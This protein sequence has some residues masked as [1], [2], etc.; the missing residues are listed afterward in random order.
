MEQKETGTPSVRYSENRC[1]N[2]EDIWADQ[3]EFNRLILPCTPED[4][5]PEQRQFWH[6]KYTLLLN[7]EL[8]EVLDETEFK[9]HRKITGK[10]VR[11]NMTEELVDVFKYWMCLCQVH[12]VNAEEIMDEYHR[13]SNVVKQRYFQEKVLNYDG[14]IVGV[15]IDGVL[16]DYPRS[17]VEFV[18]QQLG[19]DYN[20]KTVKGYD[21]VSELKL[22]EHGKRLKHLYRDSGQKRFIPVVEGARQFL[23]ELKYMGYIVVLLTSRPINEYK[24]IFADTQYWLAA[25]KLHYD[26]I[27]FDE[28]KGERLV[29]E[30]GR[31][32]VEFFVDDVAGFAN[33]ISEAGFRCYLINKSYNTDVKVNDG[34]TRV[35]DLREVILRARVEKHRRAQK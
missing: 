33:G 22:G 12:G 34:V 1:N 35:D 23:E 10:M 27:L 8:M 20:C 3:Y 25:N 19:T 30:F 5:T 24:R 28:A 9:P 29:K 2:L 32:K 6:E 31:D 15:D 4:M 17:F 16:A 7:K 21:I 14:K 11:S 13:K 26:A 18:N